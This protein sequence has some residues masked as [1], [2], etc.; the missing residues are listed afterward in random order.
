MSAHRTFVAVELSDEVRRRALDLV[1]RL[2]PEAASVR[3][4]AAEN[5]HWTLNFLGQVDDTIIPEVCR[6]VGEAALKTSRFTLTACGAGAFPAATRPRT[7]WLGAGDGAEQMVALQSAVESQLES[8]GFR[9]ENRRFHP[10]V[11]L[12]R[13]TGR[14]HASSTQLP[15]QLAQLADFDAGTMEVGE[16]TVFSSQL[17]PGGPA[18]QPL[19]RVEL[20]G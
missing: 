6:C 7:L 13:L 5:L 17:L 11:T 19:C 12:G 2:R 3:W 4:V 15:E 10:H 1:E 8:L 20:A 18:Y 14:G 9:R 16:V